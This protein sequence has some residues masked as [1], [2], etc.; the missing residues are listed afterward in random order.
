[1][2][3]VKTYKMIKMLGSDKIPYWNLY[4]SYDSYAYDDVNVL[5]G[6]KWLYGNSSYDKVKAFY[7]DILFKEAYV[8]VELEPPFPDTD[9]TLPTP[10]HR[11]F[12]KW[13]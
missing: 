7:D 3:P 5:G 13:L 1:M 4:S 2:T 11:K 6:T 10:V 8:P 9:P 12:F